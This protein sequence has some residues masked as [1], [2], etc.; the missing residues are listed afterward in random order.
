IGD[1]KDEL[2]DLSQFLV[3][4][5]TAPL[6]KA[7]EKLKYL[8]SQRTLQQ[9][10]K[11]LASP[12]AKRIAREKKISLDSIRGSGPN[13]EILERD[14]I[15][16]VQNYQHPE[17]SP[18]LL[19]PSLQIRKSQPLEGIRKVIADRMRWSLQSSA[20]L[21]ITMQVNMNNCMSV[22][23]MINQKAPN[24]RKRISY[25][26]LIALV[27]SK[28]LQETKY[29]VFN[30]SLESN[31]I[32][33]YIDD[34][35][36]GIATATKRGLLV[37]VVK[38]SNKKSLEEINEEINHLAQQAREGQIS[39][40]DLEGSTFTITNLGMF[41]VDSFTPIINPPEVA[42]LGIG[43]IAKQVVAHKDSITTALVTTLSLSFDHQVIDGHE[44]AQFLVRIKELL[45][46]EKALGKIIKE[47]GYQVKRELIKK[48]TQE[49][50]EEHETQFLIIGAG[51]GGEA[52]AMR[53]AEL[54][55]KVTIVERD[56]LGGICVNKG[57]IP[58]HFALKNV[59][60][61]QQIAN[62]NERQKMF[63][64]VPE[65]SFRELK[66]AIEKLKHTLQEGIQKKFENAGIELI[67]GVAQILDPNRVEI[68]LKDGNKFQKIAKSII[69][70][71]GATFE[72]QELKGYKELK[73][74]ILKADE[75]MELKFDKIPSSIV[76]YGLNNPTVELA[77]FFQIMGSEVT[78]L[79]PYDSLLSFGSS[80]L[81]EIVEELLDFRG[82]EIFK[83]VKLNKFLKGEEHSL[84]IEFQEA[85]T[86]NRIEANLF[87]NAFQRQS[88]LECIQN[89]P[90]KIH[91]NRPILNQSLQS[92][93]E[94]IYFIGDVRGD[95]SIPFL[96]YRASFEGQKLA[97][98]LMGKEAPID[99]NLIPRGMALD[100]QIAVI[101][102]TEEQALQQGLNVKAVQYPLA[103]NAY[104]HILGQIEGYVMLI[105]EAA[106]GKIVGGEII[107]PEALNLIAMIGT[108][109][110]SSST[111]ESLKKFPGFHPSLSEGVLNCAWKDD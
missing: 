77:T 106:S 109:I 72:E 45:E 69:V 51:P 57:C 56:L 59:L 60:L 61:Q 86:K 22:R 93:I 111:I 16:Y 65:I 36:L 11:I 58:I 99:I 101:G 38:Q 66:A 47:R 76:L 3:K 84:I 41:N 83:Q 19:H 21:T 32:L 80:E 87:V 53:L 39:L 5:E 107:G 46:D 42:I 9:S 67:Q 8:Q 97:E 50:Q 96:S 94:N 44:A 62:T 7:Q 24:K 89:I 49:M 108:A 110:A 54:G 55:A 18:V 6:M 64:H 82:I 85:E 25:T 35:N 63:S 27:V 52:C 37:P 68:I 10:G 29:S 73:N 100:L 2:P 4:H 14:I 31:Q 40:E 12:R 92:S 78:V 34:I 79:C 30:A 81:K 70:A 75:I 1:P 48:E 90:V 88:N 74:L 71:T 28:V 105:I 17:L 104:A 95:E 103:Y 20:Q 26:A 15:A 43:R 102:L 13:G 33:H 98:I 91:N 23:K